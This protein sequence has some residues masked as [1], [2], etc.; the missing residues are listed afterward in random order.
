MEFKSYQMHRMMRYTLLLLLL[1]LALAARGQE[2]FDS[3]TLEKMHGM[4]MQLL[5]MGDS[6]ISDSS[7]TVRIR[8][9]YLQIPVLVEIL[10]IPGS[11]HYPFDSLRTISLTYAPD[12]G[13]RVFT[14]QFQLNSGRYRHLGAVQLNSDSLRLIPLFDASDFMESPE[15]SISG[16]RKW[17]GAMYYK[18]MM[19]LSGDT[20]FYYFFGYDPNDP[21]STRKLVEVM[22]FENGE[23]ILGARKFYFPER[24][25]NLYQA[26]FFIEY[27]KE[28]SASLN[29]DDSR[30]MIIYDHLVPLNPLSEA[31]AD[32]VPDGSY[33]GFTYKNGRWEHVSKVFH[34]AIN[35]FDN[36]PVPQPVDFEKE[37]K[38]RLEQQKRHEKK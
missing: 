24:D 25:S 33:E 30:N 14:W 7:E 9:A 34:E 13:F 10:K 23:L 18:A 11:F 16:A 6:M 37:K 28:A 1:G 27:K 17:Y 8:N 31:G 3:L 29:F 32:R 38:D 19:Q 12:S 5:A 26:R 21:F 35:E 36:P 22:H 2:R 20:A 15:D 4:E